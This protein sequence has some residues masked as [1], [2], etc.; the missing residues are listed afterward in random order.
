[1]RKVSACLVIRANCLQSGYCL[2]RVVQPVTPRY[3]AQCEQPNP[4]RAGNYLWRHARSHAGTR[5]TMD[6]LILPTSPAWISIVREIDTEHYIFIEQRTT[7]PETL[8]TTTNQ[9]L[10]FNTQDW[11][12][13]ALQ[14]QGIS[15]T[16]KIQQSLQKQE[17]QRLAAMGLTGICNDAMALPAD[18]KRAKGNK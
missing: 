6:G 4:A 3:Y 14:V 16:L 2:W 18:R 10:R 8:F 15:E 12:V 17:A 1:M 13:F 5:S 9:G 7:N 11:S